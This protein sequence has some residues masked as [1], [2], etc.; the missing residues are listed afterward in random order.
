MRFCQS[1]MTELHR[2]IGEYR[3]VPAGDIGVGGR[4]IGF[5]FGQYRRLTTQHESGVLTGK[6]LSWGGSQVRTEATG[7][8]TVFFAQEMLASR[9]ESFD[10]RR[11]VVSGSGNVAIYAV[12]KVQELG[13]TVVAVSD[14]MKQ[15]QDQIRPWI[16]EE[17]SALGTDGFGRSDF[18]WRLRRHF[19]VNRHYIAVAALKALA[20]EGYTQPT[21]IQAQAI[22]HVLAR[23]D[24]LGIAQTGTGKTGGFALPVLELLFPGGHPDREQRHGPWLCEAVAKNQRQRGGDN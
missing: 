11:V 1:F 8:G 10:G 17:F 2:H 15:V 16:P 22:P 23:R 3:D 21:P 19:E 14:Y 4:E 6:G 20:D 18:R 24:V 13:G 5:L 7:Y 9:G 12:E